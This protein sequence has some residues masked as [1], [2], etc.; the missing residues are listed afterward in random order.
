MTASQLGQHDGVQ[1][2]HQFHDLVVPH[3]RR[4]AS[5]LPEFLFCQDPISVKVLSCS[6]A[7]AR[8]GASPGP[9]PDTSG[10]ARDAASRRY[11][12]PATTGESA[13]PAP[14]RIFAQK[15]LPVREWT[16]R[17]GSAYATTQSALIAATVPLAAIDRPFTISAFSDPSA[18][19]HR[20]SVRPSPL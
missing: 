19:C 5:R 2:H 15:A 4:R 8:A 7:A 13:I 10:S 17:V 16:G 18:D 6:R 14:G 1:C 20:M 9:V 3:Q 11:E 12:T